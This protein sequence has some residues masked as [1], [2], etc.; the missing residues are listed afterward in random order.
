MVVASVLEI[1]VEQPVG[2]SP[3]LCKKYFDIT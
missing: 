1:V 3:T 2:L